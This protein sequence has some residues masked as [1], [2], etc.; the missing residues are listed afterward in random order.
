MLKKGFE[1]DKNFDADKHQPLIIRSPFDP[2]QQKFEFRAEE[3]S[4]EMFL[5]NDS[6]DED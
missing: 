6:D 3:D 4:S 2:Y 1:E 5:T